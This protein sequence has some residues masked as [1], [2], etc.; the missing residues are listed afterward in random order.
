M[1][2][3]SPQARPDDW[4]AQDMSLEEAVAVLDAKI[5]DC[6]VSVWRSP[7]GWRA[8]VV[9]E[10][11]GMGFRSLKPH[12]NAALSIRDALEALMPRYTVYLERREAMATP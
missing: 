8:H 12:A 2:A 1:T 10:S 11:S 3:T 5:P 6:D 7:D 4:S 9:H